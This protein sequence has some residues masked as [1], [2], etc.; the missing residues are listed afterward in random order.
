M[1]STPGKKLNWPEILE[2]KKTKK[3]N[4]CLQFA[5]KKKTK[6]AKFFL[7]GRRPSVYYSYYYF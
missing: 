7:T 5:Q 6:K 1:K 2:K 4:S 3:A